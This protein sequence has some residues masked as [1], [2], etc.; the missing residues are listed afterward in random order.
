M[1]RITLIHADGTRVP[2]D[3]MRSTRTGELRPAT[4]AE[5]AA[6]VVRWARF[7]DPRVRVEGSGC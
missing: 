5:L 4:A 1:T 6:L 3:G 7:G 2:L